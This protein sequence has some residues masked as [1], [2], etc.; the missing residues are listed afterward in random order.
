MKKITS[1]IVLCALLILAPI[2]TKAADKDY[3]NTIKTIDLIFQETQKSTDVK[4]NKASNLV[5]ANKAVSLLALEKKHL[6][7]LAYIGNGYKKN[8]I[9]LLQSVGSNKRNALMTLNSKKLEDDKKSENSYQ[10]NIIIINRQYDLSRK[11]IDN[12]VSVEAIAP[13]VNKKIVSV[14]ANSVIR[15]N[16]CTSWTYGDW[17]LCPA[18]G[19]QN[20]LV[21]SSVPDGCAGGSPEVNRNCVAEKTSCGS[22]VYS[23]WSICSANGV[24]SR[25]ILSSLPDG[26]TDGFPELSRPCVVSSGP[27]ALYV[28]GN[29]FKQKSDDQ[30]IILHGLA[31]V[32]PEIIAINRP[33]MTFA[34]L[35]DLV[36]ATHPS[37]NTIRLMVKP[38]PDSKEKSKGYFFNQDDYINRYLKPAVDECIKHGYYVVLDLHYISSYDASLRDDKLVPFWLKMATIY[39]NNP[40][41]LFEIFNEPVTP[42]NW[43]DWVAVVAQPLVDAIREIATE[44]II[45]VG[46]PWYNQ[47]IAGVLFKPVVGNNITYSAHIYPQT[48]SSWEKNYGA[49]ADKYPLFITEWGYDSSGANPVVGTTQSF[50]QPF[51]NWMY[52][53]NLSWS[54]FVADTNWFPRMFVKTAN[55]WSMTSQDVNKLINNFTP[56]P[57]SYDITRC[58]ANLSQFSGF[59]SSCKMALGTSTQK[60][61]DVL[62]CLGVGYSLTDKVS[63]V[64][65]DFD[66]RS[67]ANT[68]N[69]RPYFSILQGGLGGTSL[70]TS[71]YDCN[72]SSSYSDVN[73]ALK[74]SYDLSTL[75]VNGFS[76]DW[77]SSFNIK[78]IKVQ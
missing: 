28:D 47:N 32:D 9:L 3:D 72:E 59:V 17:G 20:R 7:E 11:Y 44:N 16:T 56:S 39:K 55:G 50:G 51:M 27:E 1:G 21:I 25:F 78:K 70:A 14:S 58:S 36:K 65:L 18:S 64:T 15:L 73:F 41:I 37:I 60:L 24:Q 19:V 4:K 10:K 76:G 22:W 53:R 30:V 71:T 57:P 29:S 52:N 31:V 69:R 35:L 49:I 66:F 67:K 45:I 46:G 40:S 48:P 43:D 33:G 75:Y 38:T 74:Q 42:N 13:K 63:A 8:K 2:L 77:C 6:N 5:R 26:C 54:A 62:D 61:T 23:R 12:K 34:K 68:C